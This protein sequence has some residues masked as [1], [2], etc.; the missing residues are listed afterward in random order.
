MKFRDAP[1]ELKLKVF[2]YCCNQ[3]NQFKRDAEPEDFLMDIDELPITHKYKDLA[4]KRIAEVFKQIRN[5]NESC[6]FFI[7]PNF[8]L[9]MIVEKARRPILLESRTSL[10]SSAA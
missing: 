3:C 4:R 8:D 7:N 6:H 10:A 1:P 9:C 5:G 2:V